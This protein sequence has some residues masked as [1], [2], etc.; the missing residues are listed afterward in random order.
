MFSICIGTEIMTAM[1][2]LAIQLSQ[3]VK[4]IEITKKTSKFYFSES[5][6]N[7]KKCS[8]SV[9]SALFFIIGVSNFI[10]ASVLLGKWDFFRG[11]KVA[12]YDDRQLGLTIIKIINLAIFGPL[13]IGMCYFYCCMR[14]N[15]SHYTS[16]NLQKMRK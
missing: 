7:C 2:L 12:I 16:N 5:S 8:V 15:L 14:Y 1:G 13:A 3:S 10:C 9:I 4:S 6:Y 11:N